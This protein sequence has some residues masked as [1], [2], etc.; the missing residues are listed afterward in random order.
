M[1]KAQYQI[2][3]DCIYLSRQQAVEMFNLSP[4]TIEKI[5]AA[6]GAKVKIGRTA[7]YRRDLLQQYVESLTVGR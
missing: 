3:E 2:H 7:R 4:S 1:R 5:A 6:S